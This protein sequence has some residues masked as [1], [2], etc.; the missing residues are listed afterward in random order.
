[1]MAKPWARLEIGYLSH[2][3][4]LTLSANAICLWHEGKSYCDAQLTDGLIPREALKTFRFRGVASVRALTTPC[5]LTKPDGSPYASLWD[6]HPV[7]FKMHDYLDHNDCRDQVQARI[8][9]ADESREVNRERLKRWRAIKKSKRS[10]TAFHERFGNGRETL[11]TESETESETSTPSKN[12]GVAAPPPASPRAPLHDRSH[13]NHAHCGRICLHA[14]LF[15]ELV[16]RRNHAEADREI[17]EW[18]LAIDR[19]W[20]EGG[21]HGSDEPGDQFDFWKARYAERWPATA[22]NTPPSK[23]APAWIT[24][25]KAAIA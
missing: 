14:S 12:E 5:V 6:I 2:P 9:Q 1:M 13:R 17:R 22:N 8:E 4:F 11:S 21:P 24:R 18:A 19:D 15:G 7:G 3:K 10:E 16:R 25:A 20:Q 23:A